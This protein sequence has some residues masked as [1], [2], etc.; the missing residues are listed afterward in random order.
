MS[1]SKYNVVAPDDYVSKYGADVVRLFLMFIGPWEQGGPWNPRGVEGVVRFLN[2][3]KSLV[4]EPVEPKGEP[5]AAGIRDL[6]R[7]VHQALRKVSGDLERF[8]FNTVVSTLM[9]LSNA[10]QRLRQTAVAGTP[11]WR[12][13][14]EKLVLMLAP[15]APHQAEELWEALGNPYSVHQQSW[16]QWS[17]ELAAEDS[18]EI[19]VQVNGKLRDRI[20]VPAGAVEEAVRQAVLASERVQ[21]VLE[22]KQ[23]RKFIYVPGKLVNLVIG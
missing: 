4:N 10:M 5:T 12:D 3:V 23:I 2:R 9:E 21:E 7:A 6:Q 20:T 8:S 11:E 18:M 15:I 14:Q 13:A 1:K 22:G 17:E 19:V 16:P